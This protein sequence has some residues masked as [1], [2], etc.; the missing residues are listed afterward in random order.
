MIRLMIYRQ[1]NI[2]T[3]CH[4][5]LFLNCLP[6]WDLTRLMNLC[7]CTMKKISV[8]LSV[9]LSFS[10]Y[11]YAEEY[12]ADGRFLDMGNGIIKDTQSGMMWTQKD[13]FVDLGHSINWNDAN[14]YVSKLSTGGYNDWRLPTIFELQAI[15][16][17]TKTNKD[18]YG[19]RL[20][21]DPI[22][23]GSGTYNYWSSETEGTCCARA[24][25]FDFGY[26]NKQHRDFSGSYGV[27]A[28]R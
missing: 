5:T 2:E 10:A 4:K 22:F 13:S 27:R 6:I 14:K 18:L 23:A 28:V 25:T 11:S 3:K 9:V 17:P 24:L 20:K 16:E 7:E 21:L 1:F 19:G 12:S 15:Y 8:I 26:V